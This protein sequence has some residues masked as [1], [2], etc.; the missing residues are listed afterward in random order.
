M[1]WITTEE[2]SQGKA[3]RFVLYSAGNYGHASVED[4]GVLALVLRGSR[5]IVKNYVPKSQEGFKGDARKT[6]NQSSSASSPPPLDTDTICTG[7]IIKQL[8]WYSSNN[9]NKKESRSE[10]ET[11]FKKN[12]LE[13]KSQRTRFPVVCVFH[14][15]TA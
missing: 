4:I 12:Q 9:L 13:E 5:A 1:Y 15:L 3:R 7:G 6:W 10:I 14:S 11:E 8:P 2:M